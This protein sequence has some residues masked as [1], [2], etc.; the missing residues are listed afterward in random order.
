MRRV[1]TALVVGWLLGVA[2]GLI[3][4]AAT[5]AWYEHQLVRDEEQGRIVGY[6]I[7]TQGWQIDRVVQR[8]GQYD[9]YYLRRPRIRLGW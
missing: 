8:A 2:T 3:G 5:G 4:V 1:A 9:V 6:L 7:N